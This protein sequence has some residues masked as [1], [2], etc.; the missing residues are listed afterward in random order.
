MLN[1]PKKTLKFLKK[2]LIRQQQEID[3][4]LKGVIGDD[5]VTSPSLME[6][7]EPGTDSYIA[8]S[9]SKTLVLGKQLK[10]AKTGI[11]SALLKI[12]KGT[13]G[14][15]EKCTKHIE[16]GRLMIMPTAQYCISC[17]KQSLY[18]KRS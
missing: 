11:R 9:H 17:S 15:C 3:K 16:V 12:K 14:K 10:D 18:V 8:D 1:F 2:H 6:S 7:S 5:P 13:Y 4:N